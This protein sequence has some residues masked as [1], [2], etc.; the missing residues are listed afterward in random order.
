M[1]DHLLYNPSRQFVR[2]NLFK[3]DHQKYNKSRRWE[4]WTKDIRLEE[5]ITDHITTK[6][7]ERSI[8]F[9]DFNFKLNAYENLVILPDFYITQQNSDGYYKNAKDKFVMLCSEPYALFTVSGTY[10]FSF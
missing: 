10:K 4:S 9:D 7:Y 8:E 3:I 5:N 1:K 6:F 2:F